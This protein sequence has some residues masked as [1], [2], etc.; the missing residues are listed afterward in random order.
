[1]PMSDSTT[2]IDAAVEVR[3]SPG[4]ITRFP[5]RETW[6]ESAAIRAARR[7]RSS[8][9]MRTVGNGDSF[10]PHVQATRQPF[11][12]ETSTPSGRA[13]CKHCSACNS[14][15]PTSGPSGL[16]NRYA[17][18]DAP[19]TLGVARRATHGR[20]SCGHRSRG[21]D[22]W[23]RGTPKGGRCCPWRGGCRFPRPWPSASSSPARHWSPVYAA[24][25]GSRSG[26]R[27]C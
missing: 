7:G 9:T 2:S 10:D 19:A 16:T 18:S 8:S 1:M 13:L 6:A 26:S 12:R 27:C 23:R 17:D 11:S 15:L 4:H 20:G 24:G 14:Y 21:G 5:C 25:A 22:C 3:Q